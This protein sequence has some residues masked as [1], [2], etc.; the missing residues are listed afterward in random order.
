MSLG[1]RPGLNGYRVKH[2]PRSNT[3]PLAK[4]L[5]LSKPGIDVAAAREAMLEAEAYKAAAGEIAPKFPM[6]WEDVCAILLREKATLLFLDVRDS[7]GKREGRGVELTAWVVS[8]E[9]EI[10]GYETTEVM[11]VLDGP[12][13]RLDGITKDMEDSLRM[14][15]KTVLRKLYNLCIRPVEAALPYNSALLIIPQGSLCFVPW[16]A[17]MNAHGTYLLENH[18]IRVSPSLQMLSE[19]ASKPGGGERKG[20]RLKSKGVIVENPLPLSERF[21]DGTLDDGE[22][23]HAEAETSEVLSA[24]NQRTVHVERLAREQATKANVLEAMR[25]AS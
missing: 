24:L 11:S 20:L 17:L 5:K 19:L 22:L 2:F 23:L 6:D 9:G 15:G 21:S 8:E 13:E 3:F 7:E 25:G 1:F 4:P 14:L 16:P 12:G 10:L 18:T